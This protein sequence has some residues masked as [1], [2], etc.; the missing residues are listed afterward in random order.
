MV[1]TSGMLYVPQY[2]PHISFHVLT[3]TKGTFYGPP[4]ANSLQ[5]LK[6]YFSIYPEDASRVVL[7]IK[8]AFDGS[9]G[10][11]RCTPADIRASVDEC[12]SILAGAKTIDLFECGRVDPNVSIEETVFTLATLI[13][14]GRISSYGLSEVNA[15]TI[16]R[17]NA[18]LT[19]AAVEVELS[20]FSRDV[21]EKGGVADTC[22]ELEIP[23]VA[24]SPLDRG[25]LTGQLKKP[26]DLAAD[27]FRLKMGYPRFQPAAF[28]KNAKLAEG[29]AELAKKK[30]VT[31]PQVALAWV[32][33]QGA[34]PLP[35][36]T[37][38]VRVEENT[39]EIT[40]TDEEMAQLKKQLD[41][42]EVE[43]NRYP[44]FFQPYLNL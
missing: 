29:V 24:Y 36:A 37:K 6:Y 23:L 34:L 26:S 39:K 18:I 8:G 28:E 19:P 40:L 7:S 4:N 30:G 3:P 16:R 9:T 10:T 13:K 38:V 21:L 1:P 14:E 33:Q 27:D 42:M 15:V 32:K 11:P 43:G 5:L 2:L 35:G 44:V 12:L 31:S 25:W 41:G 20:L 22:R 17:A